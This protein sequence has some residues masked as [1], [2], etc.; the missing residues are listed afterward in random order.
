MTKEV[1]AIDGPAGAGKSTVAKLL[2]ARLGFT[3][4][5]TGA[6]YRAVALMASRQGISDPADAGEMASKMELN[7]ENAATGQRLIVNGEN[8]S[9]LIR[10]PEIGELAS[11]LS[12]HSEIRREMVARQRALIEN[13]KIVLEGRDTTTVVCPEARL[14]VFL[15]A[16]VQ[17]RA[18]R[19]Y[20]EFAGKPNAPS[21]AA[22]ESSI[23]ERD[24]RDSTREDSPLRVAEGAVVIDSDSLSAD[25]VVEAILREWKRLS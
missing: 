18:R 8:V 20:L 9:D 15:T 16:S 24:H 14:K 11:T 23:A 1:I 22:I 12:A 19:R 13:E 5:D 17:E 7:F 2:A 6:M 21:L 10:T 4:L 25:E 3:Y